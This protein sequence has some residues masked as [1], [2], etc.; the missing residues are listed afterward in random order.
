M[1]VDNQ[2]QID[3]ETQKAA[4]QAE[5]QAAQQSERAAQES[6]AAQNP[7]LEALRARQAEL[8]EGAGDRK[9]TN[10]FAAS[11]DM[12]V[13]EFNA[14]PENSATPSLADTIK[15]MVQAVKNIPENIMDT[16]REAVYE[17]RTS[18]SER[19]ELTGGMGEPTV[20]EGGEKVYNA[21]IRAENKVEKALENEM[22]LSSKLDNTIDRY[23]NAMEKLNDP[24]LALTEKQ[25]TALE[26]TAS[27]AAKDMEKLEGKL[28]KAQAGTDRAVEKLDYVEAKGDVVR[29]R[30]AEG[31]QAQTNKMER[32]N[33]V[34]A[35]KAGDYELAQTSRDNVQNVA[36]LTDRDGDDKVNGARDNRNA[37]R[38]ASALSDESLVGAVAGAGAAIAGV[39]TGVGDTVKELAGKTETA[40][41]GDIAQAAAAASARIEESLKGAAVTEIAAQGASA[42]PATEM[43]G[44]ALDREAIAKDLKQTLDNTEL[45]A[46][47]VAQELAQEALAPK[48]TLQVD[49]PEQIN[50]ESL[51][52]AK[53]VDAKEAAGTS[54]G[55][56]ANMQAEQA[57]SVEAAQNATV[58][59]S[60]DGVKIETAPIET[61]QNDQ[62]LAQQASAEANVQQKTSASQA[63][64]DLINKNVQPD[65]ARDNAPDLEANLKA[66]AEQFVK[67]KSSGPGFVD[68]MD[69]NV[70]PAA[71]ADSIG[72]QSLDNEQNGITA[73]EAT[74]KMADMLKAINLKDLDLGQ[75]GEHV[76]A[77]EGAA[78]ISTSSDV[79]LAQ[80]AVKDSG[81]ASK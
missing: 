36:K 43:G 54:I 18:V 76:E 51:V 61:A 28:E 81:E 46:V 8:R 57:T 5:Q 2:T 77:R 16:V 13:D 67:D 59:M 66:A 75:G 72:Q 26:K 35:I 64:D 14:Q 12:N 52:A 79:K 19:S 7:E 21:E 32:G 55:D 74:N 10:E 63:V 38:G 34:D 68:L 33:E 48:A 47:N 40:L 45:P 25:V 15:G 69:K 37:Q 11:R 4:L 31:V 65:A 50:V 44:S 24:E 30:E 3:E 6:R 22:A 39:A 56:S 27:S 49:Q 41:D 29:A 60:V 53:P 23:A 73:Q 1:V 58:N 17:L 42:E 20:L 70:M 78:A 71:A 62:S 80:N 9:G